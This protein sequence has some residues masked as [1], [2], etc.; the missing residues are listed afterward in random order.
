MISNNADLMT[1]AQSQ[2]ARIP[3]LK[4]KIKEQETT[5]KELNE[6]IVNTENALN[7]LADAEFLP[8]D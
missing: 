5:I 2:A 8:S 1:N 3:D 4:A 7:A 6:T